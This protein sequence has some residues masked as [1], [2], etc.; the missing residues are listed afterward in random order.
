MWQA[1]TL[2][3]KIIAL[4]TALVLVSL[5]IGAATATRYA[6]GAFEDQLGERALSVARAVAQNEAIRAHVGRP[7][8]DRAIQPVAERTRMATGVAY[9]VVFDMNR[10]RYSHPLAARIGER[11]AG[12]DEGPALEQKSYISRAAGVVGPSVR[13]FVPVMSPD[14]REQVG[15]VVVGILV[16]DFLTLLRQMRGG[17]LLSLASA[18][19][20]GVGGAWLLARSIKRQLF[21]LEP[22]QIAHLLDERVAILAAMG[23]G[24][25]AINRESR[26]TFLNAEAQ[27]LIGVGEE[28]VGRDIRTV[29]PQSQL[30][31][32][33]ESGRAEYGSQMLLG[34]TI[35]VV[36]R[37]PI[38]V[39]GEIVGAV[40]TFRDRTEVHRLAEGLT[41]VTQYV[42]ALRAQNHESL[43]KLHAIAGLIQLRRYRQAL[44]YIFEVTGEQQDVAR[45]LA[46]NIKDPRVSGILLGK[47]NRARERGTELVVDR[48]S[49]LHAVPPPLDGHDLVLLI[50]NLLENAFDAVEA[51]P[52][53]QRRVQCL[54]QAG[55]G[56]L[57]QVEDNGPGVPPELHERIFAQG[58][59]TKP[60]PHR[61]LGLALVRELVTMAGGAVTLSSQ[62]GSTVFTITVPERGE[63]VAGADCG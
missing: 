27:R 53:G 44:Q 31:A 28:V 61:G 41:G 10:V 30:P 58:F 12:G 60:G 54:V 34:R 7:G 33:L 32:T 38:R 23:E 22:A 3:R 29:I 42:D 21:D 6:Y 49:R 5:L 8:G 45:F 63:A 1:L 26:I 11:F 2:R 40:A 43:N 4:A 17:L 35:V 36:N 59:S 15:V 46:A 62:P 20:A 52:P 9:V 48:R 14:G 19:A 57:V 18:L 37:V 39:R 25:I 55:P 13:A 24:L 51:L 56:L 50:G 47:Y 16:P